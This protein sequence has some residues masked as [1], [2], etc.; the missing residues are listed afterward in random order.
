M[1]NIRLRMPANLR[2]RW[3]S[4]THVLNPRTDIVAVGGTFSEARIQRNAEELDGYVR[5]HGDESTSTPRG[6]QRLCVANALNGA[7]RP[8]RDL[9]IHGTYT[10]PEVATVG[11]TPVR[12]AFPLPISRLKPEKGGVLTEI[13][14]PVLAGGEMPTH[15]GRGE[16]LAA[17]PAARHSRRHLFLQSE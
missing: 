4:R 15:F 17:V 9:V 14:W 13:L 7:N 1:H 6:P 2:P 16:I 5:E 8:T 3:I 11:L 10:D 12:A